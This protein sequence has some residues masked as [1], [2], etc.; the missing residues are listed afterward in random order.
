VQLA[1]RSDGSCLY[2][3]V[4]A[5]LFV[6]MFAY[7]RVHVC[8]CARVCVCVCV[9]ERERERESSAFLC[10]L[11]RAHNVRTLRTQS[12]PTFDGSSRPHHGQKNRRHAQ[13]KVHDHVLAAQACVCVCV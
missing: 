2:V 9:R 5:Y 13:A 8:M 1:A 12:E 7:K 4:C 11:E 3:R 10:M 6:C